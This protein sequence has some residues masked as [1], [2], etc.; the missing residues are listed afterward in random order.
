[1][2][3]IAMRDY[4]FIHTTRHNT[5]FI[6]EVQTQY[7]RGDLDSPLQD[8]LIS[9]FRFGLHDL[10]KPMVDECDL[11]GKFDEKN[12]LFTKLKR[13]MQREQETA[14]SAQQKRV[15]EA[16]KRFGFAIA[17]GLAI[18]VPMLVMTEAAGPRVPLISLITTIVAI[19][20]F[21]IF[22]AVFSQAA[23]ENLLA[24]TAAY[25]GVLIVFV[26]GNNNGP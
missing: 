4:E 14:A 15:R 18:V 9:D 22:V 6:K 23:P 13:A 2:L 8:A 25:A 24:A 16:W 12:T 19:F 21:A 17:G 3:A 5:T 11:L 1:M 10:R 20:L 26:A 7:I